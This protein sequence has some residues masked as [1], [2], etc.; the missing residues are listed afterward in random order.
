LVLSAPSSSPR[1]SALPELVAEEAVKIVGRV[2]L[3]SVEAVE[4]KVRRGAG[5]QYRVEGCSPF[6][7]QR[8]TRTEQVERERRELKTTA[9]L[10]RDEEG[11]VVSTSRTFPD[12]LAP[13]DEPTEDEH[14]KLQRDSALPAEFGQDREPDSLYDSNGRGHCGV[15]AVQ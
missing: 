14:S 1:R 12:P 7:G 11:A 10:G 9:Y 13:P 5:I 15:P 3:A 4:R 6:A 8:G 2:P